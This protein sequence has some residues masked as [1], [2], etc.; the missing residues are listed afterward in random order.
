M[1]AAVG[2]K[3]SPRAQATHKLRTSYAQATEYKPSNPRTYYIHTH[4]AVQTNPQNPQ[5]RLPRFMITIVGYSHLS[6]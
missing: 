6:I 2:V 1:W 3:E 5:A 4:T